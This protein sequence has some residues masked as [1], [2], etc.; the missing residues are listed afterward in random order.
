ME[1]FWLIVAIATALYAAYQWNQD[2]NILD[3][4]T[5]LFIFPFLAGG[6]FAMRRFLRK[7]QESNPPPSEEENKD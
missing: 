3:E 1:Y 4:N 2:P 5:F 7:R 6:L